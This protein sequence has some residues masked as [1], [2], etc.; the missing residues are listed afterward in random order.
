MKLRKSK[1]YGAIRVRLKRKNHRE[2]KL[3]VEVKRVMRM[4]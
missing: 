3:L 1:K 2:L 4:T